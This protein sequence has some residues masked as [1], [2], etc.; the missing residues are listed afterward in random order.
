MPKYPSSAQIRAARG[1]L[2]W[3]RAE[4]ADKAAVNRQTVDLMENKDDARNQ[5]TREKVQE[6]LERNGISFLDDDGDEGEGVRL[7][8][9]LKKN[10]GAR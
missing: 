1:L 6:L 7:R 8:K 9:S 5:T 2:G 3:S 10:D 4:L